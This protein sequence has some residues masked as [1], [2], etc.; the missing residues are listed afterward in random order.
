MSTYSPTVKYFRDVVEM[1]EALW[2]QMDPI[3]AE[4]WVLPLQS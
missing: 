3:Q 1:M 4:R 2:K